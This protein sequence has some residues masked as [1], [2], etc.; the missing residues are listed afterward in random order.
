[1]SW[2][3]LV[4]RT[5][6]SHEND[7]DGRLRPA[8]HVRAVH[9]QQEMV[10]LDLRRDRYYTLNRLGALIWTLLADGR[11]IVEIAATLSAEFDAT[12]EIIASDV[13]RLI[14]RL[15]SCGLLERERSS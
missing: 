3:S 4:R 1:M 10:L 8:R 5:E 9:V 15:G 11:S 7:A 6:G 13:Q 2:L 14:E 12:S